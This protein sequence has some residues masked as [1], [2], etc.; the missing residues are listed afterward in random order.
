MEAISLIAK[1]LKRLREERNLSLGELSKK[2]GISKVMLSQI[3]KKEG[4][5]TI[6]TIWK[7]A[8]GL[9][10]SYT[11][12]LER[13]EPEIQ[14]ISKRDITPQEDDGGHYRI[15]CYYPSSPT[16]NF[17]LFH[18]ELDAGQKHDSVG[19]PGKSQEY[20]MANEGHLTICIEDR[21]YELYPEDSLSF[22]ASLPHRYENNGEKT[23]EATVVNLYPG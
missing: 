23:V 16:R 19:H 11:A 1:N 20:V 18:L 7:I 21:N 17:E 22:D 12:L 15:Y 14:A 6:N 9:H 8:N 3:E 2:S 10:V 4:N 13:R 5:P